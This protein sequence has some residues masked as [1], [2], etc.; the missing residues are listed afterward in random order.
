MGGDEEFT[1]GADPCFGGFSVVSTSSYTEQGSPQ[2]G[3]IHVVR[4]I[5][6]RR[7]AEEKYR[8]LFE[9]V[10]EGVYVA[11]PEGQLIDCNDAFVHMLGYSQREELLVL[12]LN[13]EI[14]V[15]PK[16]REAF[17]REIEDHNYVRNFDVT[18]RRKDGTLLL[19]VES[20]FATRNST[21]DIERYQGFVLDMTEKRRAEDEM[22]RRNRELNALNAMAVVAAQ[23]FDLDEILNLT[24]RQ[25]VTLF[26]AESGTVYLSDTMRPPIAGAPPGARAAATRCA[27]QKFCFTEGFGDLV[28]RSRTEV[29]T[30]E[31]LA[32]PAAQGCRVHALRCGPFLDLGPVLG[33]GRTRRHHGVVQ[34]SGIHIFQQ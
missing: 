15:D 18:L 14:C 16:Q 9:Q 25:V 12:N 26:G 34:R 13:T 27:R 3:T 2:K 32:A 17:R 1:E 30:A 4:D 23:S 5:T 33:Q 10:Q 11:N 29:V 20:S 22:R 28:M 24:L 19:A 31:Y 8:L 21:G 7:S 6:D